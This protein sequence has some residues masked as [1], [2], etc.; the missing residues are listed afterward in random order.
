MPSVHGRTPHTFPR[1][2]NPRA[3]TF[4]TA[5]DG[6][7]TNAEGLQSVMECSSDAEVAVALKAWCNYGT[8]PAAGS[9]GTTPA[10][11]VAAASAAGAEAGA[12]QAVD[13]AACDGLD[14]WQYWLTHKPKTPASAAAVGAKAATL[15]TFFKKAAGKAAPAGGKALP[16]G[17]GVVAGKRGASQGT[18]VTA[19]VAAGAVTPGAAVEL[20]RTASEDEE[21]RPAKRAKTG[22][23][24]GLVS[25]SGAAV[26]A[27]KGTST[28]SPS[29]A[30]A[31]AGST[32]TG[33]GGP[34][35]PG[36]ALTGGQQQQHTQ[37]H[38]PSGSQQGQQPQGT[39]AQG[40]GQG[41]QP[42][43]QP[44]SRA[45][46][47]SGGGGA[48]QPA[49]AFAALM[50]GAR[51]QAAA[52]SGKAGGSQGAGASKAAGGE[53]GSQAA[54]SRDARF[55]PFAQQLWHLAMDPSRQVRL[56]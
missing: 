25:G 33:G 50:S 32:G 37:K 40:Q 46:V 6:P 29:P 21:D 23:G 14:P 5:A 35:P 10:V 8:P 3:P 47:S 34:Q 31:S 2:L 41:S 42:Q 22:T 27:T 26:A 19:L 12:G 49:N 38:Q 20:L 13:S 30:E 53:G 56:W 9:K 45:N 55:P 24:E 28:L 16:S 7:P 1:L 15:D 18:A 51:K 48:K 17:A 39:A 36:Q 43:E 44:V 52:V 11:P 54:G 4:A